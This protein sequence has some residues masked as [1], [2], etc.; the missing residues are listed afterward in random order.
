MTLR[1]RLWIPAYAGMS[2]NSYRLAVA[3]ARISWS[4]F[5]RSKR[6]AMSSSGA[7][8]AITLAAVGAAFQPAVA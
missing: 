4:A 1:W 5:G 7:T 6:G 3:L 2:G 8:R